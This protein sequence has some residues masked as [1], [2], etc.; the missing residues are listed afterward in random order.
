MPR[1]N[2]PETE[3]RRFVLQ[4]DEDVHG[5]SGTGVVADGTEYSNGW[6]SLTWR[7]QYQ[8]GTWYQSIA[9]VERLH[10]HDGKTHVVWIDD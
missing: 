8:T 4:R 10:G 6:C 9:I 5:N 1:H 2:K 7:S 3:S